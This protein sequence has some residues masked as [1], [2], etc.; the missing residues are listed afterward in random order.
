MRAP[1]SS[2]G[3]GCRA[4]LRAALFLATCASSLAYHCRSASAAEQP[5]E[6]TIT[7][8][9]VESWLDQNP[10]AKPEADTGAEEEEPAPPPPPRHRGFVVESSIGAFGQI[11]DM[12]HI[13]PIAP[14]YRLQFGYEPLRFLMVFAE[15]DLMLSDTSYANPPPPPRTY[16][17]WDLGAGLR[18]TVK[19]SERVGLYLQGSLGEAEVSDDVLGIY[20]YPNANTLHLYFAG[21][22]GVEWYQVS[23]HLALA[24]H[25]GVRDYTA[26]FKRDEATG[27]PLAWVSGVALRYTF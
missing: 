21:E 19:V 7:S 9:E 24:L 22:L 27:P 8:G 5:K 2:L 20:G 23:P 25:G 18:G 3:Q 15:G 4:A 13:S 11:G 10:S 6:R 1:R 16:A 12:K 26:T 14:W 17:L